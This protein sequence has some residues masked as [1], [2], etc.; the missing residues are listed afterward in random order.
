MLN[1]FA[2]PEVTPKEVS[3]EEGANVGARVYIE[4]TDIMVKDCPSTTATRL[5]KNN[6][7]FFTPPRQI[8]C[9]RGTIPWPQSSVQVRQRDGIKKDQRP[10]RRHDVEDHLPPAVVWRTIPVDVDDDGVCRCCRRHV[11]P[12]SPALLAVGEGGRRA[13][14]GS[15]RL[16]LICS[17]VTLAYANLIGWDGMLKSR[18]ESIH[19][20]QSSSVDDDNDPTTWY[21]AAPP[22]GRKQSR[23]TRDLQV[24]CMRQP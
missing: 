18:M 3:E 17:N 2:H 24:P 14:L 8:G 13:N 11:P 15:R 22:L 20:L 5:L 23:K 21:N 1:S 16:V 6:Y 10:R 4:G 9:P 19:C 12:P 7:P